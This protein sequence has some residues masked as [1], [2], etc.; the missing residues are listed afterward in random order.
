MVSYRLAVNPLIFLF[1]MKGPR[2][3][4]AGR[5]RLI[6]EKALHFPKVVL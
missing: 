2:Y 5:L 1:Q 6:G 4:F 3:P